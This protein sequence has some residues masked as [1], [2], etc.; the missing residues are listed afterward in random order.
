M[1][2]NNTIWSF[3]L[4]CTVLCF[5][6]ILLYPG[7]VWIAF[8]ML[9]L[10]VCVYQLVSYTV[11]ETYKSLFSIKFLL[12]IV[13]MALFIYL[14]IILLQCFQFSVISGIQITHNITSVFLFYTKKKGI[15]CTY[16]GGSIAVVFQIQQ[17]DSLHQYTSCHQ[18]EEKET[19][20]RIGRGRTVSSM[21][22]KGT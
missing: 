2:K 8:S 15:W 5:L 9:V 19:K 16:R 14:K 13:P 11:H 21:I 17:N 1:L 20:E 6:F 4:L 10:R 22:T 12:K 7:G 18:E 3:L